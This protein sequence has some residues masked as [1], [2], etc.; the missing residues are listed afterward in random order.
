MMVHP[1]LG[2]SIPYFYNRCIVVCVNLSALLSD[3]R[4]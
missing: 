3:I 4:G 1:F 2:N